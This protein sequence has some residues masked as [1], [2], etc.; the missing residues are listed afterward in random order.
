MIPQP[1]LHAPPNPHWMSPNFCY[2]LFCHPQTTNTVR[3][4]FMRTYLYPA[5]MCCLWIECG[6][7][8]QTRAK[9]GIH[10]GGVLQALYNILYI[11]FWQRSMG[12]FNN[13]II[14]MMDTYWPIYFTIV[15]PERCLPTEKNWCE[16]STRVSF[17]ATNHRCRCRGTH[18]TFP[19][20]IYI[21]FQLFFLNSHFRH[22]FAMPFL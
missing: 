9:P 16:Q 14:N 6:R 4:H 19:Q 13:I 22:F 18:G 1:P 8:Q 17:R 12:H 15:K 7:E 20:N 3:H 5:L 2:P 10:D 21:F 11:C